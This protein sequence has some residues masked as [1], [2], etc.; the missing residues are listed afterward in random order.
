MFRSCLPFL[1]ALLRGKM[2]FVPIYLVSNSIVSHSDQG[3][4]FPDHYDIASS[5]SILCVGQTRRWH[6]HALAD[7]LTSKLEFP[8]AVGSSY[9][10][11]CCHDRKKTRY[12]NCFHFYSDFFWL[13]E[14]FTFSLTTN[15]SPNWRRLQ[16]VWSFQPKPK[17]LL[18]V[19][20]IDIG[21]WCT[22][23]RRG[24]SI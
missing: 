9:C 8:D 13:F 5:S 3:I 18:D 17:L 21:R 11:L 22:R 15:Q 6:R 20:S 1:S 10:R 12:G 23:K 24:L 4:L 14:N 16:P 2:S 19:R 7:K